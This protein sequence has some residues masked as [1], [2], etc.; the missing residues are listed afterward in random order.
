MD[1]SITAS[2]VAWYGAITGT[3]SLILGSYVAFRDRVR[4]K[5]WA[6]D[7]Y[8]VHGGAGPYD[9]A[10]DYVMV[11]VAN[12]GRRPIT[13]THVYFRYHGKKESALLTDSMLRG[14]KELKEGQS[15][16]FLA[17]EQ[18]LDIAS[19]KAV[20]VADATGREWKGPFKR[21]RPVSNVP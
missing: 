6:S 15:T 21:T 14:A 3:L 11:S 17:E 18:G 8:R 5:V 7:N 9:P 12:A 4:L 2:A 20:Y 10:K 13:I 19:I 16:I 1:I